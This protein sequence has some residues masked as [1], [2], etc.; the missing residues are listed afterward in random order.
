M[1]ARYSSHT[2]DRTYVGDLKV[3]S[4][5]GK[6]SALASYCSVTTSPCG[7]KH[8]G[9]RDEELITS[10]EVQRRSGWVEIELRFDLGALCLDKCQRRKWETT[11]GDGRH[12]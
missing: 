8:W 2:I 4:Q 6:H 1:V 5:L 12:R 3:R 7:S 9:L 11:P 10:F